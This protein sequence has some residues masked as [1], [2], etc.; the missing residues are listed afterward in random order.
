MELKLRNETPYSF[1]S[2]LAQ[3]ESCY[4]GR[5]SSAIDNADVDSFVI[6]VYPTELHRN[7]VA[8]H[9]MDYFF[10]I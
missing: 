7:T 3:L 8:D 1:L 5:F 2:S 6:I 4:G 9:C 10:L